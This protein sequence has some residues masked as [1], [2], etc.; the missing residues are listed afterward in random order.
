MILDWPHI[1]ALA[2]RELLALPGPCLK[3][4][5]DPLLFPPR[6][7]SII[8][9]HALSRLTERAGFG[10]DAV[11]SALMGCDASVMLDTLTGKATIVYQDGMPA[12]RRDHSIWHEVGH[13]RL[14]HSLSTPQEEIEAHFFAS[15]VRAPDALLAELERRGYCMSIPALCRIFGLSREAARK[16]FRAARRPS[17]LDAALIARCRPYLDVFFHAVEG[18]GCSNCAVQVATATGSA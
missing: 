12:P 4:P 5:P 18:E 2:Y 16:K 7:I 9:A 3:L 13:I 10:P 17:P 14:G 15:Q 6:G 11:S 8:S 1:T